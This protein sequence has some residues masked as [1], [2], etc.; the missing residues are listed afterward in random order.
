[1]TALLDEGRAA[2]VFY[3][4][5][6]KVLT[7]SPSMSNVTKL[8]HCGAMGRQLDKQKNCSTVV[9]R[10]VITRSING[11]EDAKGETLIRFADHI[12]LGGPIDILMYRV[13]IQET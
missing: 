3:L 12:K 4:N 5:F 13:A 1:M 7:L 8:Q 9:L 11:L 6:I 2:H 10:A